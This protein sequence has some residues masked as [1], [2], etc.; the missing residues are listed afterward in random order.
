MN[1]HQSKP[2]NKQ[3]LV[4]LGG[5]MAG[6]KLV[7]DLVAKNNQVYDLTV[8]NEESELAYNRIL[9]SPL[10]AGEKTF[11][12]TLLQTEQWYKENDVKLLNDTQVLRVDLKNKLLTII[13]VN[14]SSDVNQTSISYD[15]LVFATGS[16]P[17]V[18]PLKGCDSEGVLTFRTKQ[19]VDRM[20][21]YLAN[22]K[23]RCAV[24][25]GGLLGL[26]AAYA[27]AKQGAEVSVFHRG[28]HLLDR[29]LN[30][31]PSK[32][33][34]QYLIDN[35]IEIYLEA[36]TQELLTNN[37]TVTGLKLKSG[38]E[39]LFDIIIMAAGVSPNKSLAEQAGLVCQRAIIVDQY[40]RTNEK[41][42]YALGECVEFES[43]TFGLVAPAYEQAG[44]LA[45]YLLKNESEL[46]QKNILE[47]EAM[48][49]SVK[50]TATKL[51]VSG[52]DLFSA[53]E[54][55]NKEDFE[56]IEY[57][58]DKDNIYKRLSIKNNKILG[59]VLFGDVLDGSW[60]FDLLNQQHDIT[61]IRNHLLFGRAFCEQ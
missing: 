2:T 29:Q 44:V 58:N 31:K 41:D 5:G 32:L 24:I 26:E 33:L 15:K 50:P 49:F 14:S 6:I 10:L 51:K 12:D 60:Y 34:E 35:Q 55:D 20:L 11:S 17:N 7:S 38:E 28:K 47:N 30:N 19:D 22:N 61:S 57:L 46:Q 18:P 16:I 9:L 56:F 45:E 3:R 23:K 4:I 13:K 36:H 40:M 52:V 54:I 37:E 42:V 48:V 8:I 43:N 39:F 53:G 25:G 21:E 27:L 59:I 1:L